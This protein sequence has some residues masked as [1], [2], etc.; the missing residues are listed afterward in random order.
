M[1]KQNRNIVSG[2]LLILPALLLISLIL[3]YPL[4]QAILLSL[5]QVKLAS[6]GKQTFVGLK[7]YLTIFTFQGPGFFSQVLPESWPAR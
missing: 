6:L 7:N 4:I 1:R 3:V 5:Q 2:Y